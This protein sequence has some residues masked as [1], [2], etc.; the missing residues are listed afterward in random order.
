M[1]SIKEKGG[2]SP[3]TGKGG[4]LELLEFLRNGSKF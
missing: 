2:F 1:I 4:P 3:G